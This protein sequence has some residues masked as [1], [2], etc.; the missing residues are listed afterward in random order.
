MLAQWLKASCC[1]AKP[2]ATAALVNRDGFAM[3]T[4][5]P[6]YHRKPTFLARFGM[7]QRCQNRLFL[8]Y[9]M[10]SSARASSDDGGVNPNAFAVFMLIIISYLIGN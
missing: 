9:S 5:L 4:L 6:F 8:D 3:S 7:S 1:G 10:I 2:I